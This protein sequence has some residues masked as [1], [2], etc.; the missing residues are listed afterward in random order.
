MNQGSEQIPDD[1]LSGYL[2]KELS[3]SDRKL[4]EDLLRRSERHRKT[5]EELRALREGLQ[6]LPRNTLGTGFHQQVLSQIA[7]PDRQVSATT[8]GGSDPSYS[9]RYF[10]AIASIAAAIVLVL[11][12]VNPENMPRLAD[13]PKTVENAV[14]KDL[15]AKAKPHGLEKDTEHLIE[16]NSASDVDRDDGLKESED[17]F[18]DEVRREN[19]RETRRWEGDPAAGIKDAKA[20]STPAATNSPDA[21]IRLEPNHGMSAPAPPESAASEHAAE[22]RNVPSS[23]SFETGDRFR[24]SESPSAPRSPADKL[25]QSGNRE[26]ALSEA[27]IPTPLEREVAPPTRTQQPIQERKTDPQVLFVRIISPDVDQTAQQIRSYFSDEAVTLE[28]PDRPDSTYRF[29]VPSLPAPVTLSTNTT[30]NQLTPFLNRLADKAIRSQPPS[31]EFRKSISADSVALGDAVLTDDAESL[32]LS[33]RSTDAGYL[34]DLRDSRRLPPEPVEQENQASNR[35]SRRRQDAEESLV[36]GATK[37]SAAKNEDAKKTIREAD[38]T[39][40]QP[41]EQ[42]T[43]QLDRRLREMAPNARLGVQFIILS[44]RQ[45]EQ[46]EAAKTATAGRA[47]D[48]SLQPAEAAEEIDEAADVAPA[49]D[50]PA[51]TDKHGDN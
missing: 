17:R 28:T 3:E 11:F 26:A 21:A 13:R 27:P 41:H 35:D 2:D 43:R 42:L 34:F 36:S 18:S 16:K 29:A 32:S 15:P 31:L 20:K 39:D 23:R 48:Q 49:N 51:P 10:W 44:A 30:A 38:A 1:L 47:S 37:R 14:K 19:V 22:S 50:D 8:V 9:R 45:A 4:V 5:L 46:M 7:N 6:A 40:A 12:V 33:E 24:K 25:R